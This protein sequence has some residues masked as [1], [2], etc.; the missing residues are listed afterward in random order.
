MKQALAVALATTSRSRYEETLAD[1][2]AKGDL[3]TRYAAVAGLAQA[4][5]TRGVKA[6]ARLLAEDPKGVDR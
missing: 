1:L 3:E 4:N 2:A 6:A 5:L